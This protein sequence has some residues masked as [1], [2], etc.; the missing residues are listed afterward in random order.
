MDRTFENCVSLEEVDLGNLN[1][2]NLEKLDRTF[3]NCKSLTGLNLK[4]VRNSEKLY[5]I[6]GTFS[7][8]ED[9]K[10]LELSDIP[11]RNLMECKGFLQNTQV[12]QINL[13]TWETSNSLELHKLISI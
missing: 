13:E 1:L 12:Y 11:Q 5:S 8:C 7:D 3:G 2:K 6:S 9:L 4:A 10:H